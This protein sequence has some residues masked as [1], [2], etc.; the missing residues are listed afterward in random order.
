MLRTYPPTY[1]VAC[2]CA[3]VFVLLPFYPG[4]QQLKE[5]L[6]QIWSDVFLDVAINGAVVIPVHVELLTEF[7]EAGEA[8]PEVGRSHE[9]LEGRRGIVRPAHRHRTQL[10]GKRKLF[11]DVD[12]VIVFFINTLSI[13]G[14]SHSR[15]LTHGVRILKK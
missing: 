13:Y 3:S 7:V 4:V 10:E 5:L 9:F 12:K 8:I 6:S 14:I 11:K 1:S 2:A 15:P